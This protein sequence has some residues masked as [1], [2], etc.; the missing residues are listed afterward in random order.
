M[1]RLKPK[2]SFKSQKEIPAEDLSARESLVVGI[3][4]V[5]GTLAGKR[6]TITRSI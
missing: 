4:L 3:C 1:H 5:N 6:S 2:D